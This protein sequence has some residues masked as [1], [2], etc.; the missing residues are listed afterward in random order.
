MRG[1]TDTPDNG[2]AAKTHTWSTY[3]DLLDAHVE[4]VLHVCMGTTTRKAMIGA[5]YKRSA[6]GGETVTV[7]RGA[8]ATAAADAE[9]RESTGTCKASCVAWTIMGFTN[10]ISLASKKRS[11]VALSGEA[12]LS[13]STTWRPAN[14]LPDVCRACSNFAESCYYFYMWW[15][16]LVLCAVDDND[17]SASLGSSTLDLLLGVRKMWYMKLILQV[18]RLVL[19]VPMLPALGVGCVLLLL[20]PPQVSRKR[21]VPRTALFAVSPKISVFRVAFPRPLLTRI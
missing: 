6:G 18:A 21:V 13:S 11:R 10:H 12:L 8:A 17:S 7:Q 14:P 4:C 20:P 19:R 3:Y 9:S 15:G 16:S 2:C 5:G 1:E